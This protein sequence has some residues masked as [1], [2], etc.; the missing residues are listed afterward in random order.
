MIAPHLPEIDF[1]AERRR[2]LERV[3]TAETLDLE[4]AAAVLKIDPETAS[5]LIKDGAIP[6]ARVGRKYVI[7]RR[8][9]M[10]YLTAVIAK[11]TA[12]R[13]GG[14]PVRSSRRGR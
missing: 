2:H 13:M 10:D 6:A 11:Q 5:D 1:A 4:E 3:G 14:S 7:L 9:V 12:D 8:D